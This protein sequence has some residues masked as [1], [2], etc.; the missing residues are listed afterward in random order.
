MKRTVDAL[1]EVALSWRP[2]PACPAGEAVPGL[3]AGILYLPDPCR[4]VRQVKE[5]VVQ[6]GPRAA[7]LL[8]LPHKAAGVGL[9]GASLLATELTH[10]P[11][12]P[13]GVDSSSQVVLE[14]RN[15]KRRAQGHYLHRIGR[16]VC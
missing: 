1:L 13:A 12:K 11:G 9:S 5:F 3:T 8:H 6:N 4:L 10:L 16:P 7:E 14:K 15:F 2:L